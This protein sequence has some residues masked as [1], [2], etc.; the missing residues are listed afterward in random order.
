M[1]VKEFISKLQEISNQNAEIMVSV[2][3]KDDNY[4]GEVYIN[5]YEYGSVE[6]NAVLEG[7]YMIVFEGNVNG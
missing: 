1:K 2:S 7:D 4:D 6:L 3:D 5:H